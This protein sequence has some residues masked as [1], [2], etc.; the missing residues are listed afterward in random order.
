MWIRVYFSKN[1]LPATGLTPKLT[2]YDLSDNSIIL[3]A[4][5]MSEIENGLYKYDFSGYD[6]SKDYSFVVDGGATLS[7]YE[8][9]A[10]GDSDNSGEINQ[11]YEKLPDGLIADSDDLKRVLGLLH[12]NIFID[13]PTY[14]DD[15][16]LIGSRV[17]IYSDSASVGTNNNV[18]G[19]Y[20][21]SV[22][23]DGAGKFVNWKQEKI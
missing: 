2:G 3:N 21:I 16:N 10:D 22:D 12:E 18:I 23:G 11:I 8:R 6:N 14:D 15:N 7:D 17:R 4:V 13:L 1:G 20:A 5:D 19:T 9:Y